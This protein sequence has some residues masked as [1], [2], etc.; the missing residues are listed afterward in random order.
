M[1]R[2][3]NL[4]ALARPYF[5]A[6]IAKPL[7]GAVLSGFVN[8]ILNI[9]GKQITVGNKSSPQSDNSVFIKSFSYG[10][11][12]GWGFQVEIIDTTGGDFGTFLQLLNTDACS[13]GDAEKYVLIEFGWLI[14]ACSGEIYKYGTA[15][16][17]RSPILDNSVTS[18]PRGFLVG[19]IVE[20]ISAENANGLWKYNITMRDLSSTASQTRMATPI[21]SEGGRVPFKQAADAAIRPDRNCKQRTL[22]LRQPKALFY[23]RNANDVISS[24]GFPQSDGGFNGPK[25]IWNPDRTDPL[26]A[27]RQWTNSLTTDRYRGMFFMSTPHLIEPNIILMESNQ[28]ECLFNGSTCEAQS[29]LKIFKTYL[30][31]GGD[32]SPV[33]SFD[34]KIEFIANTPL[35]AGLQG[36]LS[37]RTIKSRSCGDD[38]TGRQ[39]KT[40]NTGVQTQVQVPVNNL[41]FRAPNEAGDKETVALGANAAATKAIET[42]SALE[43]D[44]VIQGDP[45]YIGVNYVQKFLSIIY[46]NPPAIKSNGYEC[47][48][49]AYPTVNQTFSRTNYNIKS[50]NHQISEDGKYTTTLKITSAT[51]KKE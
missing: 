2:T 7:P 41:N 43:A 44:L 20:K 37:A 5:C 51:P 11:S 34:P 25:S 14:Q 40:T 28:D 9:N 10:G 24:F 42:S 18:H 50:V 4:P 15:E 3:C 47:D 19:S 38:Q 27:I 16:V 6:P 21:G 48:W 29:G 49:L 36:G 32:C 17:G 26:T 30:V 46:L 1:A 22:K 23:R 35:G 45:T 39:F 31:N 33:I 13:I 8:M 12:D